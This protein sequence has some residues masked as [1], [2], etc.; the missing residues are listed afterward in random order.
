LRIPGREVVNGDL[1]VLSEGD[2]VPADARVISA[3][4]LS[5]D[6]SL[7]TGESVPVRHCKPIDSMSPRKRSG[8]RSLSESNLARRCDLDGTNFRGRA[9]EERVGREFSTSAKS[10]LLLL[11]L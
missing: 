5:T 6:E 1:L 10:L 11:V 3:T 9:V 2:R 4:N 7:L 8:C